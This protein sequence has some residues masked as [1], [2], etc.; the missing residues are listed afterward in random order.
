MPADRYPD[1]GELFA[2]EPRVSM[3]TGDYASALDCPSGSVALVV[4]ALSIRHLEDADKRSLFRRILGWLK[5]GGTFINA[6]QV[7][8][9][10]PE[11][12]QRYREQWLQDV[13]RAG[14][15]EA[16]LERAL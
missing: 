8:G 10:T 16:D 3:R 9:P 11:L 14:L 2:G 6:D 4:A 7:L 15:A 12:E 1:V 5:P 13:R